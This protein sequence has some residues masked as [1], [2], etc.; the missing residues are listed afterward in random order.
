MP[1]C[2]KGKALAA[3]GRRGLRV[4]EIL[5]ERRNGPAV[6]KIWLGALITDGAAF[7]RV[8]VLYVPHLSGRPALAAIVALIERN[9]G[10]L[11]FFAQALG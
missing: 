2:G 7:S 4:A 9:A 10:A 3:G 1:V 11:R 8:G 6:P 5:P